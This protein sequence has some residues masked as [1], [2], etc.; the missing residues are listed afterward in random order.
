MATRVR[1][2]S[3]VAALYVGPSPATGAHV[4]GTPPWGQVTGLLGQNK[5]KQLFRVQ[6]CNWSWNIPRQDILQFGEYA[7]IDRVSITSPTVPVSFSHRVNSFVNEKALGFTVVPSGSLGTVGFTTCISGM[8]NKTQDEKNYFLKILPEGLEADGDTSAAGATVAIGNGFITNYTFNAAVNDFPTATV[9]V[10]GINYVL[11]NTFSGNAIPAVNPSDGTSITGWG[12]FL[13]NATTSMS[14]LA[15]NTIHSISVLR[16]GDV[17]LNI[18]RGGT[19]MPFT[20]FSADVADFKL[21]SVNV[22]VDMS[23]E[24]INKLGTKFA[25]AKELNYPINVSVG[26]DVILGDVLGSTGS[27]VTLINA[28]ESYDLLISAKRPGTT[29]DHIT[30][31]IKGAKF[32]STNYTM[33]L[34]SSTTASLAFSAQVGGPSVTTIGLQMSGST[35]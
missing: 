31:L 4:D 1:N 18:Y 33:P 2:I 28:D 26:A 8:M 16:P 11:N 12:Y 3:P 10:E 27:L 15:I 29:V 24:S 21:Q 35:Y 23:R 6:N 14:G 17:T 34:N 25:F 5:V 19:T 30:L 7:P 32:D 22:A 20:G 9:N 13:P